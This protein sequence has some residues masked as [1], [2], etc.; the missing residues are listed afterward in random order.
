MRTLFYRIKKHH[1]LLALTISTLFTACSNLMGNPDHKTTMKT[2]SISIEI[3]HDRQSSLYVN[4]EE[5]EFNIS[6]LQNGQ[7]LKTGRAEVWLSQDGGPDNVTR[8]NFDLA[9]QNPISVS[10]SIEEPCFMLCQVWVK[11]A[12]QEHYA[13][14]MV[15]YRAAPDPEALSIDIQPDHT[16]GIYRVGEEAQ[17]RVQVLKGNQPIKRGHLELSLR[18]GNNLPAIADQKF[19]LSSSA[20][21][22]VSIA[23]GLDEPDFLYCH[24]RW[25]SDE[26]QARAL[27]GWLSVGFDPASIEPVVSAP[28][29]L[30][31]FW[32]NTLQEARALPEDVELEPLVT[33][34]NDRARYFR[35]SINTLNNQ[36]VHG[37]LGVPV[38][39]GP[40]PAAIIFPGAGPGWGK[41]IDLGLTPAGV[42]TLLLNVHPHAVD[43]DSTVARK[44]LDDLRKKHEAGS[45]FNIGAESPENYYFYPVFAGF[46]RAIDYIC[47][48]QDWWNG[49]N[50]VFKGSSQGGFLSLAISALYA[51]RVTGTYAGVP[52]RCDDARSNKGATAEFLNTFRYFDPANLAPRINCPI[53]VSVAFR[54]GSCPPAGVFAA[55]NA[56]TA[57]KNLRIEPFS[58]HGTSPERQTFERPLLLDMLN[59][60]AGKN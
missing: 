41:P 6:V 14:D 3:K 42:I 57:Q 11:L 24:A 29:D 21:E 32:K 33:Y 55:Y 31:E 52:Y 60:P 30:K 48:R 36:R 50:L 13:E 44:Q 39:Q 7:P 23:G 47:S 34:D 20:P 56:I 17:F 28:A 37:F 58:G 49:K 53:A 27:S 5:A 4:G 35:F 15:W 2:Q 22:T 8:H 51:D 25:V 10:G 43:K 9:Q 19:D 38:G 46:C 40:F 12:E 45:Y 59:H 16:N 1:T 26:P 18:K 54:D